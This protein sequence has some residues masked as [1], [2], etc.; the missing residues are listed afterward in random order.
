[1]RILSLTR[2]TVVGELGFYL[3]SLRSA[4]VIAD[5]ETVTY[6]LTRNKLREMYAKDPELA[7]HFNQLMLRLVAERLVI[8]NR[9]LE[10]LRRYA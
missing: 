7:M 3:D 5:V 2:G 9:R 4:S 10:A 6:E 8:A 1:M